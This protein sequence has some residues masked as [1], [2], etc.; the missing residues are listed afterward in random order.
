LARLNR[1]RKTD[2]GPP[3]A[4]VPKAIVRRKVVVPMGNRLA[5]AIV[6]PTH[7]VLKGIAR[8]TA[9][10]DRR[11]TARA[12]VN[13]VRK[14][15]V[16]AM[17]NAV[18]NRVRKDAHRAVTKTRKSNCSPGDECGRCDRSKQFSDVVV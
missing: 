2:V 16:R 3:P 12:R 4:V 13:V 5:M 7:V 9:S 14:G 1:V 11:E 15:T 18:R 17:V 6:V 10:A 8:A